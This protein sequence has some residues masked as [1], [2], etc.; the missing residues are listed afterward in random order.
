MDLHHSTLGSRLIDLSHQGSCF[1]L[2]DLYHSTL[3]SRLIDLYH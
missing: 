1:R 3:G 2:I